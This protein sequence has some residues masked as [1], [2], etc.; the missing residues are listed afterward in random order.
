MLASWI[1][2]T[3]LAAAPEISAT[4]T[5]KEISL[6]EGAEL[7]I[8]ASG[9]ELPRMG[10]PVIPGLD[11]VPVGQSR[12]IE[13]VNG[14]THAT[15]SVTYEVTPRQAGTYVISGLG[16]GMPALTLKVDAGGVNGSSSGG[17][18]SSA[19]GSA[20]SGGGASGAGNALNAGNTSNAGNPSIPLPPGATQ[21]S[22]NGAAF[23]RLRLPTHEL[24]VG[25]SVPVDIEVGTRDGVVA[26]LNGTPTLNGDAFTLD[27]LSPQPDRRSEESIGG[28]PYTVFTWHSVLAAVKPGVLSLT[29]QTPL[30]VRVQTQRPGA[31]F[32]DDSNLADLFNDPAFQGFF[33]GSTERDITVSSPPA[34]FTVLELPAEGK[35]KDFSGAVGK[36]TL[37][38]ELSEHQVTEGDPVTL[39]MR[40][41]GEGNFDRVSSPTLGSV[42]NWKT[43]QPTA[44]FTSA[45]N[46]EYRGDKTFDEPLVAT[47]PGKQTLPSLSFSYFD[48]DAHRY[49]TLHSAPLTVDVA[50]APA[51]APPRAEQT[52]SAAAAAS[53]PPASM[54][55]AASKAH[56]DGLRPDHAP[57]NSYGNSIVPLYFQP[58]YLSVPT[59]VILAFPGAWA[60]LRRR[61]RRG[62]QRSDVTRTVAPGWLVG[63][64][65][66]T[67]ASGDASGF[68]HAAR[69]GVQSALAT[70]WQVP[71]EA[72]NLATVNARLGAESDVRRLFAVAD[73]AIY[74]GR[75]FARSELENWKGVVVRTMHEETVS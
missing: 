64:L 22:A 23:V 7:T 8:I 73:E 45:D 43:Y 38:A 14:V 32:L 19:T 6:G 72:V 50:A 65:E 34:N 9:D 1:A 52:A 27:K 58:A 11:F 54:P 20:G 15:S 75:R 28:K 33:G 35:P 26:S 24:Y 40:V 17:A 61:E 10:P 60:W 48:P 69:S 25:Q 49:E 71:P 47:A 44:K 12:R 67:A 70:R 4:I 39:R 62:Q 74:S 21:M 5:P 42:E 53:M 31:Q 36:F 16:P 56:A 51:T 30:T 57:S 13:S 59:L 46:T 29:M 68:F 2:G 3:A 18:N 41:S 66:R 63:Q 55:A 37:S